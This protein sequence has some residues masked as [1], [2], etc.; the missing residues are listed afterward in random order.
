MSMNIPSFTAYGAAGRVTGS[1]HLIVT[2]EG[3]QLLLDCG[4]IQGEGPEG[5]ELNRHFGFDPRSI[6]K[7]I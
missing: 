7:V 4:L 3:T 1:K 5:Q 6:D 2:P